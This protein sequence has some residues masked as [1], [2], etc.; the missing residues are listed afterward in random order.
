MPAARSVSGC[1]AIALLAAAGA[2]AQTSAEDRWQFEVTPYFFA[3]GLDG[4]IGVR[5][6]EGDVDASFSD[7]WDNLD[8]AFM[9]TIEV[10]RGRF[11]VLFDGLYFKLADERTRSW[12][13]PAGI[14][15]AT[16]ELE[17]TT[18]MQM[19]QL[20]LA[21][22]LGERTTLDLIGGARYTQ[23]DADLDLTLTTGGLLPGGTRS[24]GDEQSWWDPVIGTRALLPLSE[25][26]T[27]M[28]Y[29]DFGGFGVGSDYTWQLVAGINWQVANHFVVKAGYRYLYQDYEDGDFK[30]DMAASGPF[31][32]VG[33]RF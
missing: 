32:G 9:G 30:W 20:A 24:V 8:S 13:G 1:V 28:L 22:R 5:G 33:L 27:A 31:L 16:G 10:R 19:Y 23:L 17:A 4:T 7:I 2:Q 18:T 6:V 12:Q 29:G 15:S 3:A 11:G 21:W 26:W 14:G 25:R